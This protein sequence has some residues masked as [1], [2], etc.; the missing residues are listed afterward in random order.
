MVVGLALGA[1]GAASKLGIGLSS[2][3]SSS[4]SARLVGGNITFGNKSD[5]TVVLLVVGA[6]LAFI[7][8]RGK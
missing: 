3:K 7:L 6:A 5:N 8:I 4:A 1:L 2:S